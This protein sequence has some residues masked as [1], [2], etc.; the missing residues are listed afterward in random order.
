M[1][2]TITQEEV[3]RFYQN[4]ATQLEL[5]DS[6]P[7]AL[8]LLVCQEYNYAFRSV[9]EAVQESVTYGQTLS[10]ALT[11]HCSVFEPEYVDK[12]RMGEENGTLT[13]ALRDAGVQ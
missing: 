11:P 9:L 10:D 3:Q 5:G 6:V 12:I 2:D 7:Y 13:E 8:G 1:N 4:L